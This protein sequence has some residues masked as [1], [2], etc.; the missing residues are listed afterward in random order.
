MTPVS[1][2]SD[3][4]IDALVA[5][6]IMSFGWF[7]CVAGTGV[8]RNQF[9]SPQQLET[10][11]GVGWK[12]TPIPTPPPT[13]EFNDATGCPLYS[14]DISA[15]MEVVEKMREKGFAVTIMDTQNN[16]SEGEWNVC[17]D[18]TTGYE[19][20][21]PSLRRAICEAALRAIGG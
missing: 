19:A 10:W 9:C 4:E 17:F 13:E 7:H 15:A 1:E 6:K 11:T 16:S 20:N 21:N 5:E 14:T 18:L 2:L 12:M 3:R 8:Q